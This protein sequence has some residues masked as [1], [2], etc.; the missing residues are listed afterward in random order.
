[1]LQCALCKKQPA[2]GCTRPA[3]PVCRN[4]G[5]DC[6]NHRVKF[7]SYRGT[8][9]QI[10]KVIKLLGRLYL[11]ALEHAMKHGKRAKLYTAETKGEWQRFTIDWFAALRG[12]DDLIC[13]WV[14][15]DGPCMGL[16]SSQLVICYKR[17]ADLRQGKAEGRRHYDDQLWEAWAGKRRDWEKDDDLRWGRAPGDPP[18]PRPQEGAPATYPDHVTISSDDDDS[19]SSGL[20]DFEKYW[21]S[22]EWWE[23]RWQTSQPAAASSD[24][25]P[26][27]DWS[28][29]PGDASQEPAWEPEPQWRWHVWQGVVGENVAV[30]ILPGSG[31]KNEATVGAAN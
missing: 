28:S 5:C 11:K 29:Q 9:S 10:G 22:D 13:D 31:K 26:W 25:E 12:I 2:P 3:G 15:H 24:W 18:A 17:F 8:H 1:M 6:G 23:T 4:H 19:S 16:R 7:G 20:D 21:P 27:T 30:T 14:V